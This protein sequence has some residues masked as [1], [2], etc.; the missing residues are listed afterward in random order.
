MLCHENKIP[1]TDEEARMVESLQYE[2]DGRLTVLRYVKNTNLQV[3]QDVLEKYME[4]YIGFC[5]DFE[6]YMSDLSIKYSIGIIHM[7]QWKVDWEEKVLIW[8]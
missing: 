8:R 7:S 3:P 1:I 2:I 5:L 4:E 6:K